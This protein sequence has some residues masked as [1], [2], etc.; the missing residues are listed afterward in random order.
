MYRLQ[1][2]GNL[3]KILLV[4]ETVGVVATIA[5][6]GRP[7]ALPATF[8]S[9]EPSVE[10]VPVTQYLDKR[11]LTVVGVQGRCE[12]RSTD[13][14]AGSHRKY[15]EHARTVENQITQAGAGLMYFS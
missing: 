3:M 2:K 13:S 6:E 15:F 11:Q 12:R 1:R 9:T 14:L 10:S 5:Q 7:C 4:P 8:I